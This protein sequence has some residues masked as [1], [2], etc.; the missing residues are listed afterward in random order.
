MWI[1][2]ITLLCYYHWRDYDENGIDIPDEIK[3]KQIIAVIMIL[4]VRD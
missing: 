3:A 1:I 2:Q 4:L